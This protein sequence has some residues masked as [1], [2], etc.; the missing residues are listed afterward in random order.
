MGIRKENPNY[1]ALFA[2]GIA[3]LGAGVAL[4]AAIGWPQGA[5]LTALGIVFT[6]IGAKNRSKWK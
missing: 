1:R 2:I 5:G 4:S 3:F 6:V